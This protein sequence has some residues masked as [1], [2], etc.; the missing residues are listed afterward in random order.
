M[1]NWMTLVLL[2]L[3][4]G[5]IYVF[6]VWNFDYWRRRGIK[7]AKA[8]PLVGNFPSQYTQKRNVA[9]DIDDI[10]RQYNNTDNFVGVIN[11]RTPQLLILSPEYVH[12]VYVNDFRYFYDNEFALFMD[13]K[14]DILANNP[15]MLRGEEWKRR[16]AELTPGLTTSRT[17]SIYPVTQKIVDSFVE[18]IRKETRI[19]PP[20]GLDAKKLSLRFTADVVSDSVLGIKANCLSDN[21]TPVFEMMQKAFS[22]STFFMIFMSISTLLP[23]IRKLYLPRFFPFEVQEF[24]CDL[25]KRAIELRH[26]S[27]NANRID[28][29]NY[30]IELQ[31]KR[32]LSLHE[33]TSHSMSFLTDGFETTAGVLATTLLMLARN[34]EAQQ[35]VRE[36]VGTESL[37]IEALWQIPYLQACIHETIRMFPP[38]LFA[39]KL[40]TQPYELVNKDGTRIV[41]KRDDVV[42]LPVYSLHYDPQYYPDPHSFKPER[43]LEDENG[44]KKY[45]DM[46][47]YLGFGDGPRICIGMRFAL[48]QMMAALVGILRN[49]NV[50]V[51]HKTR[52]DNQLDDVY[53]LAAL[54]G[55]VWL[56]FEELK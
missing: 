11:C 18:Y 21:P 17:A 32:N 6:L 42:L 14:K 47:V 7:Q 30:M 49:F 51:N 22:Q 24:F 25:M 28:F 38:L 20:D 34:P 37:S 56:D 8:Y 9:Y 26:R 43:F 45:R 1:L 52:S 44:I 40:C 23:G 54:K 29:L 13:K 48:T 46:G 33:V 15:F 16:R 35:R 3:I 27:G 41:L 53:F 19:P 5:L 31:E 50:K 2:A 4:I 55:G 10:Y 12:K 36:E 39:R